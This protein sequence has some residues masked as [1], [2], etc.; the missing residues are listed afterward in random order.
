MPSVGPGPVEEHGQGGGQD[1][2]CGRDEGD[3]PAGHAADDDGVPEDRARGLVRQ[4]VQARGQRGEECTGGRLVVRGHAGGL[5][6]QGR[7]LVPARRL[8]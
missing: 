6:G 3:L 8:M 2:G 5:T 4:L 7:L 1:R